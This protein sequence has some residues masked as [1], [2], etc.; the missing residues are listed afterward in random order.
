[1]YNNIYTIK[2]F[3]QYS[4]NQLK[5]EIALLK[6][7]PKMIIIQVN[8]DQASNTYVRG[9]LKDAA[10]V[11]ITAELVKLPTTTTERQ[12]IKTIKK[13]AKKCTGLIVQLPLPKHICEENIKIAI[14]P[15][16]DIDGFHPLTKVNAC[17]P[18]G[19]MLYLQYLEEKN[20]FKFTGRNAVVVGRS[21]IVGK[22]MAKLL[23]SKN[24]NV[25]VLHSKTSEK[26]KKIY[27]RNAD[28]V[29][30]A[31][32]HRHTLTSE[33]Q[34]KSNAIIVDVG[35][36]RDENGKLCGDCDTELPVRIQTPVPGGVGLLTRFALLVNL[37]SL[38]K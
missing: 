27:I 20:V 4:K 25:T 36:N 22:P 3:V 26:D 15:E 30:V 8:D 33:Y 23:L 29:V 16:K 5:D 13:C 9:K 24:M 2:E 6:K 35:I 10:E 21:N 1:M 11:G 37:L 38:Y 28:L 7:A 17:T 31:T 19:I 12:L 32:G 34:Y 14:P 18:Q